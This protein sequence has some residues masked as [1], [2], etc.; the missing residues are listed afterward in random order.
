MESVRCPLWAVVTWRWGLGWCAL[1]QCTETVATGMLLAGANRAPWVVPGCNPLPRPR[2]P[3]LD[4]F[5]TALS[6]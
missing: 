3:L 5:G 6:V 1:K 2:L 4:S